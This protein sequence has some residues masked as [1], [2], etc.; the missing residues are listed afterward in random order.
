MVT[1]GHSELLKACTERGQVV[2]IISK[3]AVKRPADIY[4]AV[5]IQKA[6]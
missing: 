6:T 1:L 4:N 3:T 2:Q 5:A